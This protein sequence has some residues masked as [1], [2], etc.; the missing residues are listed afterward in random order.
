MVVSSQICFIVT[1][2]THSLQNFQKFVPKVRIV[3]VLRYSHALP[4]VV[5]NGG[6]TFHV[7]PLCIYPWIGDE[8]PDEFI[9]SKDPLMICSLV[10]C[11]LYSWV[12]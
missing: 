1:A 12:C 6:E 7:C 2:C 10:N 8:L 9:P 4:F 5:F 11:H 3:C